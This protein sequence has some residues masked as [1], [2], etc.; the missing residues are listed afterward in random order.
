[1]NTTT[2]DA[3]PPRRHPAGSDPAMRSRILDG[4]AQVFLETG[5]DAASMNDICRTAGVSKSTLYVYFADK[6]A[7]FEALIEQER[8]RLFEGAEKGLED[9]VPL[10]D[11]LARY[12]LRLSEILCSDAV[13]R[14]QRTIIAQSER[15]PDL[16]VRF[17]EGGAGRAHEPLRR[18]LDREVGAGTLVIADTT[19]AAYQLT[20]LC[21]AG[22][23][24]QR[25]FGKRTE[26]PDAALLAEQVSSAIDMFLAA[27]RA[28]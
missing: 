12:A 21:T 25:L 16:S 2:P 15:K 26:P 22:I 17:Y 18:L 27:Y 8:A 28:K 13:I 24:R 9:D 20:E 7:L 10:E 3:P 19:L 1:M 5:F 4:A 14:A 6:D 11:K 23:W